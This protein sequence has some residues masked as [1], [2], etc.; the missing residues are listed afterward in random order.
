M[1]NSRDSDCSSR[2][3]P[4]GSIGKADVALSPG[5]LLGLPAPTRVHR[6][7]F[8]AFKFRGATFK[9]MMAR[10]GPSWRP[11]DRENAVDLLA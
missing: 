9:V 7:P 8:S 3:V 2:V 11:E 4:V 5:D 1:F 6:K 10:G